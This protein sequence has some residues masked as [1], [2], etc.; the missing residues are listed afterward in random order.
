MSSFQLALRSFVKYIVL[1]DRITTVT[2][3]SC[4]NASRRDQYIGDAAKVTLAQNF[5]QIN[6]AYREALILKNAGVF[7]ETQYSKRGTTILKENDN[8]IDLVRDRDIHFCI[9]P[10]LQGLSILEV[11]TL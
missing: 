3:N 1:A 5:L 10:K 7:F 8:P 4:T 2:G 9:E 11:L 6:C